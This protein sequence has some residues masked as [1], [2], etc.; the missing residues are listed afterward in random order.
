[1]GSID[2][3]PTS[4]AVQQVLVNATAVPTLEVNPLQ[5]HWHGNV[6]V[7]A[8]GAVRDSRIW[9][10]K[11]IDEYRN[12]HIKSFVFFTSASEILRAVPVIFDY[13]LCIPFKRVRQL[14]ATSEGFEPVCPSTW[15]IIVY[16]PPLESTVNDIDK[17]AMFYSSFRDIGR[18]IYNEYAG[19]N[20]AK[21]LEYYE[22]SKGAI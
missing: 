17:L 10:N 6:F 5:T 20:W 4:D 2:Y 8:K 19:D 16:G 21:D 1:M 13:P 15:N 3:D 22:E 9:F 14:R 12:G 7:S 18:V 11:T